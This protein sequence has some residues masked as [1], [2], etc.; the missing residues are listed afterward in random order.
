[1]KHGKTI[2]GRFSLTTRGLKLAGLLV[3]LASPARAVDPPPEEI[4]NSSLETIQ[5][6]LDRVGQDSERLKSEVAQERY[7]AHQRYCQDVALAM[8]RA[9]ELRRELLLPQASAP[10]E[11]AS[12][13]AQAG[14][15]APTLLSRVWPIALVAFALALVY[16][17]RERLFPKFY[18]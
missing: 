3:L 9:A 13:P 4:A 1:M 15:G 7:E 10:S 6:Y 16:R 17:F 14:A 2:F 8:Y 18:A 12:G 11:S 5:A